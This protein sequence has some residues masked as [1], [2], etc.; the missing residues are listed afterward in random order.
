VLLWLAL[1][2]TATSIAFMVDVIAGGRFPIAW[3]A[4][5]GL[6][7]GVLAVGF[8]AT[9]LRRQW[10]ALAALIAADLVYIVVVRRVF[11]LEQVASLR[12]A[13]SGMRSVRWRSSRSAPPCSSCS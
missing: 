1:F 12:A 3:L 11:Q 8:T 4:S 9:S 5:T 2:S 7:S 6:V 10:A 13:S